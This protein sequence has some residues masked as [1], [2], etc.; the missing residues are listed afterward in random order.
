MTSM[1][2]SLFGASFFGFIL[3]PCV[4]VY[5]FYAFTVFLSVQPNRA[6]CGCYKLFYIGGSQALTPKSPTLYSEPGARACVYLS[7]LSR[8]KKTVIYRA[9]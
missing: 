3:S 2:D 4:S 6:Q 7:Q 5:G 9:S 1:M 8:Q